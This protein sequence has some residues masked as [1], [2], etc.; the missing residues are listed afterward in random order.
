VDLREVAQDV[1]AEFQR[2]SRE[3]EKLIYFSVTVSPNLPRVKADSNRVRQVLA[4]LVSNGFNYTPAEGHVTIKLGPTDDHSVQI[5][6]VDDGIGLSPRDQSRLF[7]RFYR[8][9]DPLV[10]ASAG[11]GLGLAISKILIEMHG[12]KIWYTSSG[13]RGEGCVFSFT[14][15]CSE[16]E[17]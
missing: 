6:V 13:V 1:L 2:R 11:T 16:E 8:G 9:D 12:G 5:D 4:S 15:P 14:L 17:E 3:E 7:E 10:L